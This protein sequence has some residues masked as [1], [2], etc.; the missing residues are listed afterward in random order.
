MVTAF[1]HA[2]GQQVGMGHEE[3]RAAAVR[4]L[5]REEEINGEKWDRFIEGG[6]RGRRYYLRKM[7]T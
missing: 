1:F 6:S 2:V 4:H 7:S 5:R 3:V